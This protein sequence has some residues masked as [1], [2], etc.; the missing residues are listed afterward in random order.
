MLYG[1]L[2]RSKDVATSVAV[3]IGGAL[4]VALYFWLTHDWQGQ[5]ADW[6]WLTRGGVWWMGVRPFVPAPIYL[7]P[8]QAGGLLALFLPLTLAL[9]W[10]TKGWQRGGVTAVAFFLLLTLL[11]TSS[12]G[13]WVAFAMA[14]SLSLLGWWGVRRVV[15]AGALVAGLV[16]LSLL[17]VV[18]LPGAST[19]SSRLE[20]FRN[21]LPLLRDFAFTGGG[22]A[23]FGG[24]YAHYVLGIPTFLY[25][26]AHNLWLDV[27]VEQ[28][29]GGVV[30]LGIILAWSG[31]LI[32]QSQ[33]APL[34]RWAIFASW[35][36]VLLHGFVDDALYG[37]LG[38]PFLWVVPGLAVLITPA[39]VKKLIWGWG[40]RVTAVLGLLALLFYRPLWAAFEANIGA[41]MMAQVELAD[42]PSNQW[43]DGR[44]LPQLVPAIAHLQKAVAL[45][46]HNASALYRL[47]LVHMLAREYETA[48]PLLQQAYARQPTHRGIQKALGF[49][50]VWLGEYER[51]SFLLGPLPETE[52][53]LRTY[54]WWWQTQN[55]PDL[56]LRA[57]EM[58]KSPAFNAYSPK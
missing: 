19:E 52:K 22:L 4:V 50:E 45:D 32:G 23:S 57:E 13:A 27:A 9:A 48:V 41:V 46:P 24:L 35:L 12:R 18:G 29:V 43:A 10:Q 38:T 8:N 42:W 26:Y 40:K 14:G 25:G 11:F 16:L 15:L 58:L 51:A 5:P 37:S 7:H 6:G 47:G 17:F 33:I 1:W 54:A 34:W 53:E 2:V 20:L 21:T 30:A 3:L 28:G 36:V 44:S 55:R 31:W 56:A 49:S 39:E